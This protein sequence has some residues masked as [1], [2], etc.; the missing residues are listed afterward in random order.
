MLRVRTTHIFCCLTV[1]GSLGCDGDLTE[2]N[3][4]EAPIRHPDEID[5]DGHP[6]LVRI[7]GTSCTGTLLGPTLLLTAAHC[8][9]RLPATADIQVEYFEPGRAA[10]DPRD[11][12]LMPVNVFVHPQHVPSAGGGVE[13]SFADRDIAVL[14][15]N[16]GA[17]WPETDYRDYARVYQDEGNSLPGHLDLYGQGFSTIS[18]NGIGTLRMSRFEVANVRDLRIVLHQTE[19]KGVCR[20]DSGGPW[21]VRDHGLVACVQSSARLDGQC[22]QDDGFFDPSKA[23]CARTLW[24]N[25]GS[26]ITDNTS[27][28]VYSFNDG[29][30]DYTR[31]FDIP[32]IHEVD[33]EGMDRDLATAIVIVLL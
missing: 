31:F 24:S 12:G 4:A 3:A 8:V 18:G 2:V 19:E 5:V 28:P 1:V 30:Y 10:N 9:D 16:D 17:P 27:V 13:N 29:T 15:K 14:E 7:G 22:G 25:L 21:M 20:G 11:F 6:G 26:I 33:G 23:R 32:F